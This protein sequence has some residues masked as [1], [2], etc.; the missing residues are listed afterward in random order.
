[1]EDIKKNDLNDVVR[2]A[3][4]HP[5]FGAQ[6][7]A[8]GITKEAFLV[9]LAVV[10]AGISRV[11]RKYEVIKFV[12]LSSDD[13]MISQQPAEDLSS[14]RVLCYYYLH[15]KYRQEYE[16]RYKLAKARGCEI[17]NVL[18]DWYEELL[19]DLCNHFRELDYC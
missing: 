10:E 5:E 15:S 3:I 17:D 14:K 19:E 13:P 16:K 6:H 9:D 11:L 12:P 4:A 8:Y 18:K 7:Q 2:D 1:M